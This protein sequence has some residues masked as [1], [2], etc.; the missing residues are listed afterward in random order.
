MNQSNII[1]K[2]NAMN[3][4]KHFK[5]NLNVIDID[6]WMYGLNVELEH[7]TKFGNLTNITHDD[8]K[9]TAKIVIAHLIEFPDYYERLQIMES[10]AD[11]FWKNKKKP[12]IF[13]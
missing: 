9:T 2:K 1:N 6:M 10:N 4:A 12:N 5:I 3:L 8:L 11:I 7:G 13:L